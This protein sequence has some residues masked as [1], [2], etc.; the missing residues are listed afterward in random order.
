MIL[1]SV[2]ENFCVS[3]KSERVNVVVMLLYTISII[4][5]CLLSLLQVV[6]KL[7]NNYLV[8]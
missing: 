8:G 5:C 2:I 4:L 3:K 7:G 1:F 6:R